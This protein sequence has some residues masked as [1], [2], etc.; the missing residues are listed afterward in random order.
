MLLEIIK[1]L[2]FSR[3]ESSFL[4]IDFLRNYNE[5]RDDRNDLTKNG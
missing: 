2:L 5:V 4:D 3:L 1:H